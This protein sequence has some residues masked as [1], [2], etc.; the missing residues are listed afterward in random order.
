MYPT[1]I[2]KLGWPS[3]SLPDGNAPVLKLGNFDSWAKHVGAV[4]N[5][6]IFLMIGLLNVVGREDLS[7]VFLLDN[8]KEKETYYCFK[9]TTHRF[10]IWIRQIYT[11][12]VLNQG[13]INLN[14][15]MER[16]KPKYSF[17]SQRLRQ[18]FLTPSCDSVS[19]LVSD[20]CNIPLFC[21][22]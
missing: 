17:S 11:A 8:G 4:T 1:V 21:T 6:V 5:T 19:D 2:F 7:F 18:A 9:L 10:S 22:D 13:S 12:C 20:K 15:F 16:P 14:P 3:A